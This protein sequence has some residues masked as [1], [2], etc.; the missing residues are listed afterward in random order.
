[1]SYSTWKTKAACKGE[2]THKEN[3]NYQRWAAPIN[4]CPCD[5]YEEA[6]FE[7]GRV[8]ALSEVEAEL[9]RLE[10]LDEALSNLPI[11]ADELIQ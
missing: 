6:I 4:E 9:E 10:K 8:E 5:C 2:P 7:A 3:C 11:D 1:M